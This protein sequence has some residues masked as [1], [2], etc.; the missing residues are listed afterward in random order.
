[1]GHFSHLRDLYRY[2]FRDIKIPLV[3]AADNP[4]LQFA[5]QYR[6]ELFPDAPIV[7]CGINGYV[8]EMLR[9][10]RN[11]TGVAELL[12]TRGTVETMLKLHP[13]TREIFVIHD[14]TS[15]GLATRREAQTQLADLEKLVTIRYMEDLTTDQMLTELR[16]LPRGTLVLS[17][18]YS[19]DREGRVFDHTQIARLLSENSPVPVYGA[20]Q[21]RLGYGIVG[22]SLLSA[23]LHGERAA[24]IAL[25]VLG[26][27]DASTIPVETRSSARMMFDHRQLVR[28]NISPNRLPAGSIIVNRP[29]SFYRKYTALFWMIVGTAAMLVAIILLQTYIASIRKR[30]AAA[31]QEKADELEERVNERT[32]QLSAVNEALR[33]EVR[34][35]TAA[36]EEISR[37]NDGLQRRSQTLEA[38]NQELEAFSYSVS[39]DLRA[40]LRH[41]EGFSRLL[42]EEYG[43]RFDQNGAEYLKRVCRASARMSALIDDLINLSRVTRGQLVRQHVDLSRTAQEIMAELQG[44]GPGRSVD[45]RIQEGMSSWGDPQLLRV[46]LGN[47]LGNAWKYTSKNDYALVEFGCCDQEG[48]K[49]WFVRDNG[50]GFDMAFAERLFGTFQRLHHAADFEGSGI[51]LA[52]VQRIIHRHE[53]KIWGKGEVGVGATFYFTLP[54]REHSR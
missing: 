28:F 4:A 41:I 54:E 13:G 7:F 9:G 19:R 23:S 17:L 5:L 6:R 27:K 8:R 42:M 43:D 12:D 45:V 39:H 31:L 21:E 51:G 53:G 26:G 32:S 11:I 37:L 29:E 18:S 44:T 3:I 36:Q 2:K 30:A 16:K 35:R 33:E 14:Y 1:M 46:M 24:E 20:H 48:E 47:L 38:I 25:E 49:V 34:Q 52:T 40:P 15:T 22:G 50:V 10:E